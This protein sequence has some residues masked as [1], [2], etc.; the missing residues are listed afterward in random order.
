MSHD[1]VSTSDKQT[2]LSKALKRV[3][4]PLVKLMLSHDLG[5]NFAIDLLKGLFVEVAQS[6]F[7]I[8]G[9]RQ[10]DARISLITGV[11]RKDVKRLRE[12]GVAQILMPE[13]I[14]LGSQVIAQWN[15]HHLYL[16]ATGMPLPLPRFSSDDGLPSFEELVKSVSTDIHPRA[17]LDE[18][19]RLGVARLDEYNRVCLTTDAFV[20]EE[21][22]SEKVFYFSQNIHD[23]TAAT[24]SNVLGG[25]R[26]FLERC[27][28]Y[29]G[30][31]QVSID[32]LSDLVEKQGM[33]ALREVNRYASQCAEHDALPLIESNHSR[34]TF[35]V[36]FYHAPMDESE[37]S[38]E[39]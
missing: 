14:S 15:A 1:M 20:P 6:D 25:A 7:Q 19:L 5:Y 12:E 21:G 30:L 37:V 22:F 39:Q 26:P 3:L 4:R 13:S 8:E 38:E 32:A 10:T 33:N 18:W 2:L 24:V 11:H 31:T 23:H 9:K 16:D 28:H 35:G 34:M 36:Y 29:Q 27:V 17:V